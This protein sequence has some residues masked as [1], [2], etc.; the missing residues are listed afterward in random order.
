MTEHVRLDPQTG[1][2]LVSFEAWEEMR[3]RTVAAGSDVSVPDI[4][5]WDALLEAGLA[6]HDR[7]SPA[8][9]RALQAVRGPLAE[10]RIERRATE[11]KSWI[12]VHAVVVLVPRAEGL[13]EVAPA[14]PGHLPDL[15]ARLVELG[16]RPTPDRD[17]ITVAPGALAEA[18]AAPGST[19]SHTGIPAVRDFWLMEMTVPYGGPVLHRLEVLDTDDCLWLLE[20]EEGAVRLEPTTSSAVWR[21]LVAMVAAVVR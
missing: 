9:S 14:A 4:E 2:L 15:V 3:R 8:V 17:A 11:V 7:L 21:R 6:E 5:A 18:I 10:L 20:R 13:L 1:G 16:P 19:A 12:G